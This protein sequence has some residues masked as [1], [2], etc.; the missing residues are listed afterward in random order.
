[1]SKRVHLSVGLRGLPCDVRSTSQGVGCKEATRFDIGEENKEW[2][3]PRRNG[4]KGSKTTKLD[5]CDRRV[6]ENEKDCL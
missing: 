4:R 2:W 3:Q 5:M 6:E 1:M